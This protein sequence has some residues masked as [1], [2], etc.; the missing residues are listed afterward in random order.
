MRL[1]LPTSQAVWFVSAVVGLAAYLAVAE[2]SRP[3]P[4]VP[5]V[6]QAGG[7][8]PPK[9]SLPLTAL[10]VL[11]VAGLGFV[12]SSPLL[13]MVAPTF[14]VAAQRFRKRRQRRKVR[15]ALGG[16]LL[17]VVDHVNHQLRSGRALA[18]AVVKSLQD[19]E[20]CNLARQMSRLVD[21]VRG[22]E[23]FEVALKQ[24][25]DHATEPGIRLMSVTASVLAHTGGAAAGAFDRLGESLRASRSADSEIQTQSSQAMASATM[26]AFLPVVF[27]LLLAVIE[28]AVASFYLTTTAG[29]VCVGTA[30]LLIISGW[31]WM[32]RVI[33]GSR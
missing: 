24:Q 28:P 29:A 9:H 20:V 15:A 27:G 16:E 4:R 8:S 11:G 5:G 14:P 7:L 26:M 17:A 6:D 10:S 13:V 18:P 23:A 21:G 12:L 22:G 1:L 30:W 25:A 3:R 33:W 19:P 32:D 2:L 31:L